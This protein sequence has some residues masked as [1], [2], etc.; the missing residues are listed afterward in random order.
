M[1][2]K[3]TN[4]DYQQIRCER[5]ARDIVIEWYKNRNLIIY[6]KN[7][8]V[9]WFAYLPSGFKCMLSTDIYKNNF[10][11]I[12][13]NKTTGEIQCTCFKRF[14]YMVKP[15]GHSWESADIS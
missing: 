15:A 10:F 12:T 6:P 13:V 5:E 11:E 9:V 14:E 3:K 4:V 2:Q 8:F 1:G 7:I